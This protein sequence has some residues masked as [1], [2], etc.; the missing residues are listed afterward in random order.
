MSFFLTKEDKIL[1]NEVAPRPHNSGHWT[2]DACN[3]SQFEALVRV[4]FD[5]PI[6]HIKYYHKRKMIN[7]LGENYNVIEKS[8]YKKNQKIYVYGKDQIKEG[9]KLGHINILS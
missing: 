4:I 3:I 7:I 6:P 2:M 1:I 9:R 5:M 8:L